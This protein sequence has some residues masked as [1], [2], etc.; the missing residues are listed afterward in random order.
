MELTSEHPGQ[1]PQAPVWTQY[2]IEHKYDPP[3]V[4]PSWMD[5]QNAAYR[6]DLGI[7][8]RRLSL[9]VSW[10]VGLLV[11]AV[12][13]WGCCGLGLASTLAGNPTQQGASATATT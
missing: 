4:A 1:Q 7:W 10:L 5:R 12:V 2:D 6:H 9:P 13:V 3:R 11:F 8:A